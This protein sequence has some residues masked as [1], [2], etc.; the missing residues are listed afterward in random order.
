MHTLLALDPN[1]YVR[2]LPNVVGAAIVLV[3]GWIIAL[4]VDRVVTAAL[5]R[6]DFDGLA[7]RTGMIDDLAR[8]GIAMEPSRLI[9]RMGFWVI[10]AGAALQAINALELAEFSRSLGGF[11]AFLPHVVI[12]VV[13][14]FAGIIVGDIVG[15]G[16][17]GAMWRSGVLYHDVT[18]GFVRTAIIVIAILIALQQLTIESEFFFEIILAAFGSLALAFAIAVGW[19]ARRFA[20]NSLS[21]RFV[22]KQFAIGDRIS[23]NGLYGTVERFDTLCTVLRTDEGRKLLI[24]NRAL[25]DSIVEVDEGGNGRGLFPSESM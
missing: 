11:V 23:F 5:R 24:P 9:G 16:T 10:L 1:V 17:T 19:G 2:F 14:V 25:T 20:E 21:G 13:V 12:A 8:V 4:V 18:G 6:A 15:R 22:E 7:V 3:L